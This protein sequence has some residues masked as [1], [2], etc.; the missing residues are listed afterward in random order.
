MKVKELIDELKQ[1]DEDSEV[2]VTTTE[3]YSYSEIQVTA[4]EDEDMGNDVYITGYDL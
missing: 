3:N 1:Y 4:D 2:Y